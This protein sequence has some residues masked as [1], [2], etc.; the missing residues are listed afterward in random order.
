[1]RHETRLVLAALA[2]YRL[3]RLVVEDTITEDLRNRLLN[4]VERGSKT[5]TLL[6]CPYC[7]GFWV[8]GAVVLATR[9]PAPLLSWWAIA[10]ATSLIAEFDPE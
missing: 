10:G 4:K 2:A 6:T 5:E 8:A 1:M 7:A 3:T 9:L